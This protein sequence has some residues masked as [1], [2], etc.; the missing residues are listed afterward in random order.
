M[1]G[2][3]HIVRLIILAG[4]SCAGKTPLIRAFRTH[5][6]EE[7]ARLQQIVPY[8]T[9]FPRKGEIDGRDYHFVDNKAFSSLRTKASIIEIR[10]RG[11][12]QAVDTGTIGE[13][14]KKGPALYEGNTFL[15]RELLIHAKRSDIPV[16][17]VFL[18]PFRRSD[19]QEFHDRYGSEATRR[20]V[21]EIMLAKLRKRAERKKFGAQEDIDQRAREAFDELLVAGDFDF[22][23]VNPLGEEDAVWDDPHRLRGS[24]DR[25]SRSFAEIVVSGY[26]DHAEKWP[27]DLF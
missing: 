21:Y 6:P 13:K 22:V 16:R 20:H 17:S 23:I 2:P 3:D 11:D 26:S 4:P 10:V 9:R 14:L 25:V 5:Y 1:T 15:A 27:A 8:T 24:A 12:R 18:S 19:L 7:A